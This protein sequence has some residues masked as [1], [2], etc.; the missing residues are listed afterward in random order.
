MPGTYLLLTHLCCLGM[1]L[2][3]AQAQHMQAHQT[4]QS[5]CKPSPESH[6]SPMLYTPI[7]NLYM[8]HTLHALPF[9]LYTYLPIKHLSE[10][11]LTGQS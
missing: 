11:P 1:L 8:V 2:S 3:T 4:Y 10:S 7:K 9:T 6:K 5:E